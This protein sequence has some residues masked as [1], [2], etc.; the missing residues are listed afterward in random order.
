MSNPFV[1]LHVHSHYSLLD[2]AAKIPD[3]VKKA[4][5]YKMPALALTDHGNLFGALEFYQEAKKNNIKPIIGYEAYVAPTTRQDRDKKNAK[6]FHV[7]LLAKNY[8]GYHNLMKLASEAYL[9]GFYYKPRI[10][11]ELLCKHSQGL[12]VLSGCLSSEICRALVADKNKEAHDLVAFYRDLWKDDFYIELQKNK[13]EAQN[14]ANQGLVALAKEFNIPTVLTSD[15]HYLNEND[16]RP[17][18]VL[19]C[20]QTGAIM[21]DPN[22]FH[23]SSQEFYLKSSEQMYADGAEFPGSAETTLAIAD[24]VNIDIP[25][26]KSHLPQFV[27]PA[28]KTNEQYLREL[29]ETGVAERYGAIEGEVK[30][31]FEYEFGVICK[32]GFAPYFLIVWDFINYSRS[33]GI[34]VGPGRGSAAGSIIAYALKITDLDPLRYNLLFERFL[35]EGRKEMPDIDVDFE[36]ERR[37]EVIDYVGRKYGKS[38]VSQIITF[39]TM[40][41][42]AVIRDVGRALNIPLPEVDKVAKKVPAGPK[43]TLENAL[44]TDA[45]FKSL[46]ES[47]P[48]YQ[49][50]IDI[51]KR[52]EGLNRQPG[53]H[54]AGVIIADQDISEY[55]PLYQNDQ[56][57]ITTQYSMEHVT[58]LGLLKMDFLGLSTLTLIQKIL[59]VIQGVQGKSV[60]IAKIP[61]DDKKTFDLLSRGDTNGVFQL[62]SSGI[63]ELVKKLKP[64]RFEDVVALIALYRPGPLKSGMVDTFCRCKHGQEEPQYKHPV[65]KKILEETYGVILYQEQVMQMAKELAGF[66]LTEA[67]RL[68]KAIS[69]KKKDLMEAYQKQ[70]IEGAQ[71]LHNVDPAVSKEI[72]DLIDFFSGYGFNKSHSA[73]YAL[74]TYQTAY[75][76]AHYPIE[77]MTA[78]MTI[79][80][81][82]TDKITRYIHDC[83]KMNIKILPPDINHSIAS[84]SVTANQIRFGFAALKGLGDRAIEEILKSRQEVGR[85]TSL[86]HLCEHADTRV[87]NKQV[88][89]ALVKSGAL[90][91][92]KRKRSQLF[93]AIPVAL[94]RGAN[95]RKEKKSNQ[96]NLFDEEVESQAAEPVAET[97]PEDTEPWSKP[98]E[99]QFERETLGFYLSDHPLKQWGKYLQMLVTH[100]ICDLKPSITTQIAIGGMVV[101]LKE[102]AVK[103]GQN[104]GKKMACMAVEDLSGQ[105]P[106]ICFPDAF[107]AQ[108]AHLRPD[109]IVLIKGK[110]NTKKEE[111]EVII[112][113]V[114]PLEQA[115]TDLPRKLTL[116]INESTGDILY[117]LRS[118]CGNHHGS[119]KLLLEVEAQGNLTIIEA[120]EKFALKP[121]CRLLEELEKL[122]GLE[123]IALAI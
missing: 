47:E 52:L 1:H 86:F 23:F 87:V 75:L 91:Y 88:L 58:T 3:L 8:Q 96:M 109:T 94:E 43:I 97:Y 122:V 112:D 105:C 77:F 90:D 89:E 53:I 120:A 6:A 108:K 98:Q 100:K 62:E 67:D 2:G 39:N 10:D 71:K 82:N 69:K 15:I 35:N 72:F 66:T 111:A 18:E 50:L 68:R 26:G 27:V 45:G 29:C 101:G 55:C 76:K 40:A 5:A 4:A 51:A 46:Y 119:C 73:A 99:L 56:G 115:I 104:Q 110:M 65:I 92:F 7:T 59:E 48:K 117:E 103:S 22:H 118:L 38:Q 93:H 81:Q 57:Q 121:D 9:T 31:R 20:I 28:G 113:E 64:D 114:I 11:K 83:E 60:D 54:A 78:L 85:F 24:K 61:L 16:A 84:F 106:A 33:Q 70:F 37:T 49:E 32:M 102:R 25:L 19:L 107:E 14:K 41:A 21:S 30:Q 79:E 17:H 44:E 34:P 74:L 12:I 95:I 36:A 13:I 80:S 42:R 123:A 63:R 116:H